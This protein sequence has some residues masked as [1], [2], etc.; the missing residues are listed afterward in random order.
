M[1]IIHTDEAV[2]QRGISSRRLAQILLVWLRAEWVAQC[3]YAMPMTIGTEF[4]PGGR[5]VTR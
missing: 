2:V 1:D 5:G 4:L 3:G